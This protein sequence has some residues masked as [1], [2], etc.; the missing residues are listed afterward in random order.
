MKILRT[1]IAALMI[2]LTSIVASAQPM[3]VYSMRNNARFLTDRMA[4]TL[5]L[6]AA[7]L[8]DIYCINYD[9][10]CGVNGY[11]DDVAYGY[12]YDDYME[13]VYARDYALRRLLSERQWALLMSYDYFYRPISFV[14]HRWRFAIYSH[15][16]HMN[17]FFFNAPRQFND[18]RGGTFFGGMRRG[19]GNMTGMD[20][21]VG[22]MR[23]EMQ[24]NMR[25]DRI[26][27]NY[28]SNF[29]SFHI[30]EMNQQNRA[31][32][33][34][35]NQNVNAE[36]NTN[37]NSQI[38]VNTGRTSAL[39]TQQNSTRTSATQQGVIRNQITT[40]RNTL[41]TNRTVSN[42][43]TNANTQIQQN[44]SRSSVKSSST[45]STVNVGTSGYSSGRISTTRPTGSMGVTRSTSSTGVSRSSGNNAGASRSGATAGR[46]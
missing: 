44:T 37:G 10:I 7:I 5:G 13:V 42:A 1:T 18:Y 30:G 28:N 15:D 29:N 43:R 19:N 4:Y 27:R 14:D 35:N 33:G 31:A 6:S 34:N 38:Q 23:G 45:R 16:R 12:M 22:N 9:Y 2:M 11:L 8:D 26:R 17:H 41:S 39:G 36:T 25:G 46:R 24:D 40:G 21:R 20:G 3:N 32:Y